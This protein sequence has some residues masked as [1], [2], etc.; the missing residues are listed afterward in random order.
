MKEWAD[1]ERCCRKALAL[2]PDNALARLGLGR[3]FMARR[4]FLEAAE[5]ALTAV[6][7]LYFNPPAHFLLGNALH[8]LGRT[9]EA[10]ESLRV[11]VAQNPDFV[12]AH[13]RL[14]LLYE[15]QLGDRA[16]AAEH[17]RL[18]WESGQRLKR[19]QAG[20]TATGQ[21]RGRAAEETPP[22]PVETIGQQQTSP[23]QPACVADG[24][25]DRSETITVVSGLPRSGT[26]LMMQMLQAGGLPALVD[27]ARPADADN[28]RGYF[29]FA[30]AKG[31]RRDASWLPQAKGKAV[32]I[33][34]QL[35]PCLAPQLNYRVIL[36]E[37]DL[38]EVLASQRTLLQRQGKAGADLP[39]SRL[40]QVFARQWQQVQRMLAARRIPTLTVRFRDCIDRPPEVAASLE[41][42]LGGPLDQRAMVAAIDPRLYRQR[43]VPPK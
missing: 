29:E 19:L 32:K 21:A 38:D 17:R 13:R 35:L 1:V 23:S 14:A 40:R 18:A 41:A 11:A 9:A 27:D 8:H 3:S 6:G 39:A 28:P 36:M 30:P 43:G 25:V 4:R 10:V 26:S 5:E 15:R 7:L 34:A 20:E 2:D 16:S 24:P 22:I 42:F 31:L 33:V 37:R 12:A